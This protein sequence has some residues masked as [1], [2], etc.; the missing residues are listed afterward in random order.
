MIRFLKTL[1]I[2]AFFFGVYS[3]EEKSPKLD[4]FWH[5]DENAFEERFVR[6]NQF[7]SPSLLYDREID[8]PFSGKVERLNEKKSVEQNYQSGL[9][10]GVSVIRSHDGSWVEANY[11]DGKLHGPMKFFD[12][13]GKERTQMLYEHGSLIPS[14]KNTLQ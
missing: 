9:L 5:G 10:N 4:K 13:N 12:K 6:K 3:C 7:N 11:A 1:A 8:Q 14:P 2:N